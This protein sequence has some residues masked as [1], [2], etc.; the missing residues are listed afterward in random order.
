[1]NFK[2]DYSKDNKKIV[3]NKEFLNR[4]SAEMVKAEE[5]K[6]R[7]RISVTKIAIPIAAC[8]VLAV[9]GVT[10]LKN[11]KSK[12]STSESSHIVE[13]T[14]SATTQ[15]QKQTESS[16]ADSL[17]IFDRDMYDDESLDMIGDVPQNFDEIISKLKDGSS[18]K[19][20]YK[21]DTDKFTLSGAMEQSEIDELVAK[22]ETLEFSEEKFESS[23]NYM[24]VF[25]NGETVKFSILD[26]EKVCIKS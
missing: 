7:S 4:L 15:T 3:P 25:A 6:R 23:E 14:T 22:L 18:L 11:Q 17:V 12:V 21:S 8:L 10:L 24:A 13:Q 16:V 9:G 2:E 26:D 5:E 20:L 19:K 1:M